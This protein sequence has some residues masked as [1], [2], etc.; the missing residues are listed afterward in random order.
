MG[1]PPYKQEKYITALVY[2]V[3][4]SQEHKISCPGG[5]TT[6]VPITGGT[7]KFQATTTKLGQTRVQSDRLQIRPPE[8]K[9]AESETGS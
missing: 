5:I 6:L 7:H 1:E 2:I 9:I 3:E 8:T 4:T